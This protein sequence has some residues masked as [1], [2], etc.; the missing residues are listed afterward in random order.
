MEFRFAGATSWNCSSKKRAREADDLEGTHSYNYD[1]GVDNGAGTCSMASSFYEILQESGLQHQLADSWGHGYT[2]RSATSSSSPPPA[3]ESF[4][5]ST[6]TKTRRKSVS[7][8]S[9]KS[10]ASSISGRRK[11]HRRDLHGSRSFRAI[12][13]IL[14]T[15]YPQE[16]EAPEVY[17]DEDIND[18]QANDSRSREHSHTSDSQTQE[19]GSNSG[20]PHG[21]EDARREYFAGRTAELNNLR[22]HILQRA[23]GTHPIP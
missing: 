4:G 16:D 21:S 23:N 18:V 12:V 19:Q 7:R 14:P 5:P 13:G 8:P 2:D 22:M 6:T 10:S 3:L 17:E 11:G 20:Y 15:S 9:S 1:L